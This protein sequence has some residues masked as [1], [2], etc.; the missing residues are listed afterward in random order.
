MDWTAIVVAVAGGLA[1]IDLFRI[2]FIKDEKKQKK[3]DNVDSQVQVAQHANDLLSGQLER[4]HETIMENNRI[5]AEKDAIIEEKN[6][7]IANLRAEKGALCGNLCI[8]YGCRIREPRYGAGAQYYESKKS[9]PNLGGD[10][11]SI[12]TLVKRKRI[13]TKKEDEALE[14][15]AE[16]AE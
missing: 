16:S 5:I 9:D 6:K 1:S 13:E 14:K 4:S 3:V 15:A 12:E 10:W 11:L 2:F 8:H 7:E